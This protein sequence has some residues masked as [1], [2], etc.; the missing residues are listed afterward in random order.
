MGVC[1]C[2]YLWADG[3]QVCGA[4]V[5]TLCNQKSAHSDVIVR[6]WA[7]P[8]VD[9]ATILTTVKGLAVTSLNGQKVPL[10]ITVVSGCRGVTINACQLFLF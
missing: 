4:V 5:F 3:S 9:G 8:G 7:I 2:M 6:W 1:T 10:D